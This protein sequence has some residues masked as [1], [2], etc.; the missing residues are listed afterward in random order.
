MARSPSRRAIATPCSLSSA[1]RSRSCEKVRASARRLV[2]L[3]RS[4]LSSLPRPAS[5]CLE[6]VDERLVHGSG[7][8]GGK[9]S[10]ETKRRPCQLLGRAESLGQPGGPAERFLGLIE[11]AG[12]PLRL[13]QRQQ[14]LTAAGGVAGI[15]GL[16]RLERAP[17]V[18][19]GLLVRELGGRALAGSVA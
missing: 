18:A 3:A 6:Q 17:V 2:T 1:P 15:V 10:A 14:Q 11:V 7:L 9:R 8:E 12:A 13:P 5:A 16:Q 4:S 19:G